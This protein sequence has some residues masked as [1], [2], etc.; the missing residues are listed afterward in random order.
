MKTKSVVCRQVL[1]LGLLAAVTSPFA[2]AAQIQFSSMDAFFDGNPTRTTST[3]LSQGVLSAF[4][5]SDVFGT[6]KSGT[7]T[8]DVAGLT[9]D[10][11]N[12]GDDKI[13]VIIG[14][15]STGETIS[16]R[17]SQGSPFGYSAGWR[18]ADG[19]KVIFY[20]KTGSVTLGSGSTNRCAV[21]F[22]GFNSFQIGG[23]ATNEFYTYSSGG[24]PAS[25]PTNATSSRTFSNCTP[26]IVTGST[27][28]SVFVSKL[29]FSVSVTDASPAL[30][31]ARAYCYSGETLHTEMGPYKTRFDKNTS[32]TMR[33]VFF[34][35]KSIAQSEGGAYLQ[36]VLNET[37]TAAELAQVGGEYFLGTGHRPEQVDVMTVS[38]YQD[39]TLLETRDVKTDIFDLN[40]GN[41]LVVHKE[42]RFVSAVN[43]ELLKVTFDTVI[44]TNGIEQHTQ[45]TGG[46]DNINKIYFVYPL[47]HIVPNATQHWYAF[48]GGTL[49]EK[50]DFLDDD[51][52]TLNKNITGL[53][54]S[55]PETGTGIYV[56]FKESYKNGIVMIWN[57]AGDNKYYYKYPH[58]VS[59]GQIIS[60]SLYMEGFE[61]SGLSVEPSAGFLPQT[62]PSGTET[63]NFYALPGHIYTGPALSAEL[64]FT[65]DSNKQPILRWNN[66]SGNVYTISSTTNLLAGFQPLETNIPWT[67]NTFTS[68]TYITEP[69]AF[70]KIES[71]PTH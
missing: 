60:Y 18:T 47:M 17:D 20:Y 56:Y 36:T 15:D 44:T 9:L 23:G 34:N 21:R 16:T 53:L 43:G 2:N 32:W 67:C 50:G 38:A 59:A 24:Q 13:Q 14:V 19:E 31:K 51:S 57:R 58:P 61:T 22:D 62:R 35:D 26:L 8:L 41:R 46:S 12:T 28:A 42:S 33:S 27:N 1:F 29:A 10:T 48:D 40:E 70:Y 39:D 64:S 4:Y 71:R 6:A 11:V 7:I 55:N 69:K 25:A 49:T 45:L 37:L 66:V 68:Q 5:G 3:T 54:T 30:D 63:I 52:M 65:S